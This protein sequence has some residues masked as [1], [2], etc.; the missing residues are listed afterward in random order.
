LD[1]LKNKLKSIV[2]NLEDVLEP[3]GT[4]SH[5]KTKKLLQQK[6]FPNFVDSDVPV[7]GFYICIFKYYL[8]K[9]FFFMFY[10]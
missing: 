5:I 8:K 2:G 7:F 10:Y 9:I 1:I 4:I 3:D 6:Y